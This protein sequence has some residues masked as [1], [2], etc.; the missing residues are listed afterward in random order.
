MP[1]ISQDKYLHHALS[2]DWAFKHSEYNPMCG[3]GIHE[4]FS[5]NTNRFGFDFSFQNH[6]QEFSCVF[7]KSSCEV[8]FL[9]FNNC[10][11]V[12]ITC[13]TDLSCCKC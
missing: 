8:L 3:K 1:C 11:Y 5:H 13:F 10:V 6:H 12:F 4:S 9:D 2:N 7:Q